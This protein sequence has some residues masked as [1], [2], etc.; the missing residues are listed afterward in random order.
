[1]DYQ[2]KRKSII[3]A[4]VVGVTALLLVVTL[5]T[6][7]RSVDT[8]AIGVVTQL[9]KVTGRELG[10]GFSFVAPWGFNSVTE[11]DIKTQKQ[12]VQS[13]AASKDLQ[14]VKGTLVLNYRLER[15]AVSNMH[16]TVGADYADKVVT[17]SINE[18]FKAAT[19]KYT[20]SELITQRAEVKADVTKAL[21][22][23]LKQRGI[24][25]ED[26]NITNF[27]FSEAFNSA[28]EAVQVANQNVARARQELE[29]TKVQAEKDITAA[30][31]AAEAQRLQQ[32]TLTTEILQKQAIEKWDG[33]LPT[34]YA[35]GADTLFNIPLR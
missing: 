33:K 6:S 5:L 18:V 27:Q 2:A 22:D 24:F 3:G 25:V 12:E 21:Q 17:P 8:G 30:Q 1:M 19:A 14:D 11:Y 31:G 7:M 15:G 34:T 23:R 29:T 16:Q 26:V 20:A 10:E 13:Q 9:G 35:G 4:V 28:I 32:Q